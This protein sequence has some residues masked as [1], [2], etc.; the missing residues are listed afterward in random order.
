MYYGRYDEAI[1]TLKRHLSLPL[2]KWDAERAASM[3]FIAKCYEAKGDADSA[4]LWLYRAVNEAPDQREAAV[5]MAKLMYRQK[6]W[7]GVIHFCDMAL[8][9]KYRGMNYISEPEAWGALP[10]DLLSLA[11]WETGERRYA[12]NCAK[13]AL[14]LEPESARIMENIRIMEAV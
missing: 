13:R 14:E 6:R 9:V 4:D 2:A 3:R 12:L 10:W 7:K 11:W 5:Q 1:E 8:K